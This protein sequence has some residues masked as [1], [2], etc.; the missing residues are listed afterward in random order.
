MR[1]VF[2]PLL[3]IS[4]AAIL[5]NALSADQ[6]LSATNLPDFLAKYNTN[7]MPL[8]KVY[9]ELTNQDL[10]LRDQS[11]QPLARRPIQDRLA[12]LTTLRQTERQLAAKPEDLVLATTI[13]IQ[14]ESLATDDL[15]D[16][17]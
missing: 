5:P 13:V 8:E 14:T 17:S 6:K 15:F 9:K 12:A 7:S 11:G 2:I 4:A 1:R 16:L 3:L 10:P